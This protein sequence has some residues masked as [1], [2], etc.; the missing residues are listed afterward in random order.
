MHDIYI[1]MY[2]FMIQYSQ[3]THMSPA[4]GMVVHAVWNC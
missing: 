1:C 3:H 2:I 4:G